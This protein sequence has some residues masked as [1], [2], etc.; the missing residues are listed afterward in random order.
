MI[1]KGGSIAGMIREM[2]MARGRMIWT[3]RSMGGMTAAALGLIA[4]ALAG[5]AAAQDAPGGNGERFDDIAAQAGAIVVTGQRSLGGDLFEAVPIPETSCLAAAPA[6]GAPDPGFTIDASR[7]KK[8]GDLEKIRK[9]TRAG[10]IFVSGGSFVGQKLKGARLSDMC[11]FG[12]DFSQTDWRGFS[13]SG[14]GFVGVNLNGAQMAGAQMPYVLLR[15]VNLAE[16]DA[17]GANFQYGRLDGGWDGSVRN[18]MLD[19]ADLTGFRI[20]CGSNQDDGCPADRTGLSLK[21]ANLRR[22][23]LYSFLLPEIDLTGTII[24]QTELGI[25]HLGRMQGARLV[26]PVVV[27]SDRRAMMLF[28]VEARALGTASTA[29]LP[30][31]RSCDAPATPADKAVCAVPGSEMRA[32]VREVTALDG[33]AAGGRGYDQ[34]RTAFEAGRGACLTQ[35]EDQRGTCLIAA[36]TEHRGALRAMAGAPDWASEPGYRIYMSNESALTASGGQPVYGRI[37]PILLDSA[38]SILILK[39][40]PRGRIDAKGFGE[41][42]C[43][44]SATNLRYDGA[45][46]T[47]D[48]PAKRGNGPALVSIGGG[49]AQVIGSALTSAGGGCGPTGSFARMRQI[50]LDDA[51]LGELYANF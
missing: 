13:G 24:D 1:Y 10:T 17:T 51:L 26:G 36:Y 25:D 19:N 42:G 48:L 31:D 43:N 22:A 44:F 9:K 18:L 21:G 3:A 35:G 41:G 34:A 46:G 40:Q 50:E 39:V 28:P 33:R 11:F 4:F 32:L 5:P 38:N 6:L 23:S 47:L 14:L 7:L 29:Q 49:E 37:L 20:A 2:A 27:R 8:I 12:S 30:V 16:A 45:N 15:N